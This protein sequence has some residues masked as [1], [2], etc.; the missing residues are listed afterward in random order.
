MPEY[1]TESSLEGY[2]KII[3]PSTQFIRDRVVPNSGIKNRPDYRSDE[4]MLCI[5]FDGYL[6]Y[7]TPSTIILDS[8]KDKTYADMGYRIIRI[9]YFVQMSSS[10][11]KTLFDKDITIE[12]TYPHGFIDD[13]CILPAAFC[14][15]GL[16]RYKKDF[17]R[18]DYEVKMQILDSIQAKIIE[19]GIKDL[20]LPWSL[21]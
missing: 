9:P 17:D 6:H 16:C 11:I 21:Q 13:K 4:L 12:Q 2:L 19:L 14:E 1:L 20:V 15:M 18:F 8:I 3:Y 5:E 7:T 10:T